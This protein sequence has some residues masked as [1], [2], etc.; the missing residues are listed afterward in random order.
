[1]TVYAYQYGCL[2]PLDWSDEAADCLW[3]QNK[4]WNALVEI[5]RDQRARYLALMAEDPAVAALEAQLTTLTA[6]IEA[7]M[8]ARKAARAR[9][10]KRVPTPALDDEIRALTAERRELAA[11]TKAARSAAR[12]AAKE[13]LA[14]LTA[15]R[16]EAVKLARQQAAEGGL[17]WGHYNAVLASYEVARVRAMKEGT[18]LK[19]HAFDG[20]GRFT[21]QIQGGATEADLFARRGPAWLTRP[22]PGAYRNPRIVLLSVTIR[23]VEGERRMLTLPTVLHRPLP[24]GARIKMIVVT[25]RRIG[26]RFR[27]AALFTL[28]DPAPATV[29]GAARAC[30]INPGFRI[31]SDGLRVA[32]RWDTRGREAHVV[33]PTRWLERMQF[34]RE[35][36]ADLDTRLTEAHTGL[37]AWW[38]A[39]DPAIEAARVALPE[40][41]RERLVRIVAA[42][43]IGAPKLAAAALAWRAW[44]EET[45]GCRL[46]QPAARP[47]SADACDCTGLRSLEAWRRWDKRRRDEMDNLRGK[48]LRERRELYR[49]W[50]ADVARDHAVVAVTELDLRQ[51]AALEP[52]PGEETA[53]HAIARSNRQLAAPSELIDALKVACQRHGAQCLLVKGAASACHAC[54]AVVAP[55]ADLIVSCPHC[56]AIWD[57]DVN[58]AR[59]ACDVAAGDGRERACVEPTP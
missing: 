47:D 10:R 27:W 59:N 50:A 17:W 46:D 53:L 15:E 2:P 31:V 4:L 28:D 26:T 41:V 34:V 3:R 16:Y 19:F 51:I 7:A 33:L 37:R 56:G 5:E 13:P 21:N 42:P 18:E 45:Q 39:D 24:E 38:R 48:L 40:P 29:N 23:T 14:A 30:G 49:V 20:Q 11:Q 8:S 36:Q 1:M 57:Q 58:A 6:R 25:R 9:E 44:W 12:V 55:G 52:R 43:K 35:L 22:E 54:G 32:T